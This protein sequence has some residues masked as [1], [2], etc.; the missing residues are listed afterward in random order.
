MKVFIVLCIFI[1][2]ANANAQYNQ[3]NRREGSFRRTYRLP[4]YIDSNE[5][6][7]EPRESFRQSIDRKYDV[8]LNLLNKI[9]EAVNNTKPSARVPSPLKPN[10]SA[11]PLVVSGP[12]VE[13]LKPV[14][15]NLGISSKDAEQKPS[16]NVVVTI[17]SSKDVESA[18][19][20]HKEAEPKSLE[21]IPAPLTKE[22]DQNP[23][24]KSPTEPLNKEPVVVETKDALSAPPA[25][26]EPPALPTL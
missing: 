13:E 24:S 10:A 3:Y 15:S 1:A 7:L 19:Q 6:R 18:A 17:A 2:I 26:V 20:P 25:S 16:E 11:L 14:D 21:N 5:Q 8:I 4:R 12:I 22:A 23:V 9:L